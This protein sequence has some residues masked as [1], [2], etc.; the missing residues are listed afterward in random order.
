MTWFF[1]VYFGQLR[2]GLSLTVG[3]FKNF[4]IIMKVDKARN[5]PIFLLVL[6]GLLLKGKAFWLILFNMEDKPR[7]GDSLDITFVLLIGFIMKTYLCYHL[8]PKSGLNCLGL[9]PDNGVAVATSVQKVGLI[10]FGDG[11]FI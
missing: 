3:F 2:S 6:D 8:C 5:T 9:Q 4:G 7:N 10:N 11:L 1:F